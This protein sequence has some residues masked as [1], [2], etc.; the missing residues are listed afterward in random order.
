[1]Q[2]TE[3]RKIN[4]LVGCHTLN[5]FNKVEEGIAETFIIGQFWWLFQQLCKGLYVR[6]D[7]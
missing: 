1:M 7:S 3:V 4:K 5:R 2:I 6:V